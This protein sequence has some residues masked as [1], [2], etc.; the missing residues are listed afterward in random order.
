[1]KW[2]RTAFLALLLLAGFSAGVYAASSVERVT[3]F[4]RHDFQVLL[5]GEKADVGN[6]LIL[7]RTSYLPLRSVGNLLGADV[8]FDSA[9]NTIRVTKEE[10]TSQPPP[11]PPSQG[12]PQ[13]EPDF[14]Y[15]TTA[16][17]YTNSFTMTKDG[18]EYPVFA[19]HDVNY[20]VY[21]RVRDLERANIDTSKAKK[22]KEAIT[23]EFYVA[24]S[25]L[26]RI[27]S[28]YPKFSYYYNRLVI[29]ENEPERLL[30]LENY[31]KEV[32]PLLMTHGDE[33]AYYPIPYI[34]LIERIEENTYEI[35]AL[36]D[37]DYKKYTVKMRKN[38]NTD[39][40][41]VSGFQREHLGSPYDYSGYYSF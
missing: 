31:F 1:M 37:Q 19:I 36:E 12:E 39:A 6:I 35:L 24:E 14:E 3:A 41:N 34:L 5:N 27:L 16:L 40:W 10:P 15:D 7:D 13:D 2:K 25:E 22:T 38:E 29:G 4:I 20:K 17:V 8:S 9:T 21:Y 28:P 26:K 30:A 11:G 32:F 23:K 33:Y 18:R